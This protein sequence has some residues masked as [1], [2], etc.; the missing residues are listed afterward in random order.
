MFSGNDPLQLL[1]LL[2]ICRHAFSLHQPDVP[3]IVSF[4]VERREVIASRLKSGPLQYQ[5][6]P[7]VWQ[8]M[9]LYY[10]EKRALRSFI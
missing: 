9:L 8:A 6:H 5:C 3:A 7:Q 1:C 4:P 10:H 2:L